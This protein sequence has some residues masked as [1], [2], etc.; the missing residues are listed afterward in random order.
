MKY[1]Y[2]LAVVTVTYNPQH[3][4]LRQCLDSI[5]RYNDIGNAL[6]IIVVDNSPEEN[7]IVS[8][9][10]ELYPSVFFISNPQ[11]NGFGA[12]NNLGAKF[13]SSEYILF[14]NNDTELIEPVFYNLIEYLD[15][16]EDVGCLGISQ[17]G[18]Q[19]SFFKRKEVRIS[20]FKK[21]YCIRKEIFDENIFYISGAFML[22]RYNI[23]ERCGKF[24]ENI[25]MYNEEADILN[26][27]QSLG[28]NVSFLGKYHFLHKAGDRSV[29]SEFA[30]TQ[31]AR[32][33]TY[34]I[35]KYSLNAISYRILFNAVI[36]MRVK[37]LYFFIRLNLNN[38]R[39]LQQ[40]INCYKTIFKENL[41]VECIF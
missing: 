22:F 24:D 32:S 2:K 30:Y 27:I 41:G 9:F 25:F 6:Q 33:T 14:F 18:G 7:S 40:G 21:K 26:R 19:P 34:Y 13:S 16:N 8:L 5:F 35:N 20:Y 28:Y 39:F 17:Y 3:Q 31:D 12:A 10:Q 29:F 15:R 4:M 23:F 36:N 37:Q 38:V 11:N 1:E